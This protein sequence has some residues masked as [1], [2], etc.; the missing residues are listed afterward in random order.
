[1]S[2]LAARTFLNKRAPDDKDKLA[3]KLEDTKVRAHY[4]PHIPSHRRWIAWRSLLGTW[5]TQ[6]PRGIPKEVFALQDPETLYD[7][8]TSKHQ[9]TKEESF[10]HSK[11]MRDECL[12]ITDEV[13]HKREIRMKALEKSRKQR[14]RALEEALKGPEFNWS[15]EKR[16]Y[17]PVYEHS[18]RMP[19]AS[20]LAQ[21][22]VERA[23][24]LR[25]KKERDILYGDGNVENSTDN[26][27][28]IAPELE[29]CSEEKL[30]SRFFKKEENQTWLWLYGLTSIHDIHIVR[31]VFLLLGIFQV[32]RILTPST[33]QPIIPWIFA[34]GRRMQHLKKVIHQH[35]HNRWGIDPQSLL[36]MD[37]IDERTELAVALQKAR[38]QRVI[39]RK[40]RNN[41]LRILPFYLLSSRVDK[42]KLLRFQDLGEAAGF[43]QRKLLGDHGKSRLKTENIMSARKE[44]DNERYPGHY[45]ELPFYQKVLYELGVDSKTGLPLHSVEVEQM[46]TMKCETREFESDNSQKLEA[47]SEASS[48][49]EGTLTPQGSDSEVFH[50]SENNTHSENV[51]LHYQMPTYEAIHE[52]CL[53]VLSEEDER[54]KEALQYIDVHEYVEI[55]Q[56]L[57][58]AGE[59]NSSILSLP[60][61][62]KVGE[63]E[64]SYFDRSTLRRTSSL[65]AERSIPISGPEQREIENHPLEIDYSAIDYQICHLSFEPPILNRTSQATTIQI[66]C[67]N[68]ISPEKNEQLR[69]LENMMIENGAEDS[70][71]LKSCFE[72][73][74][75][76]EILQVASCYSLADCDDQ[77]VM[78]HCIESLAE[79]SF[80]FD[81]WRRE[82]ILDSSEESPTESVTSSHV[83]SALSLCP[84]SGTLPYGDNVESSTSNFFAP[85]G[86][87][88]NLLKLN[89]DNTSDGSPVSPDMEFGTQ[90]KD[91]KGGYGA[92]VGDL[93]GLIN[94]M[95]DANN[96]SHEQVKYNLELDGEENNMV[97]IQAR[98]DPYSDSHEELRQTRSADLQRTSPLI[99]S[100]CSPR[101]ELGSEN[102]REY[103]PL[104][105]PKRKLPYNSDCEDEVHRSRGSQVRLERTGDQVSRMRPGGQ[106]IFLRIKRNPMHHAKGC[107]QIVETFS[108]TK[109]WS[110]QR[111]R[112]Q[113]ANSVR[114]RRLIF[115]RCFDSSKRLK[116]KLQVLPP[117]VE[118]AAIDAI[119]PFNKMS[120]CGV[121]ATTPEEPVPDIALKQ[122]LHTNT[123]DISCPLVYMPVLSHARRTVLSTLIARNKKW[124]VSRLY[125]SLLRNMK[126]KIFHFTLS[127]FCCLKR[128]KVLL[129]DLRSLFY[130]MLSNLSILLSFKRPIFQQLTYVFVV[131]ESEINSE[132]VH[133]SLQGQD[134]IRKICAVKVGPLMSISSAER[135]SREESLFSSRLDVVFYNWGVS[136]S[137]PF[138]PILTSRSFGDVRVKGRNPVRDGALSSGGALHEN[139]NISHSGDS[140]GQS[141]LQNDEYVSGRFAER[142]TQIVKSEELFSTG[143][144]MDI[145]GL[146]VSKIPA[147]EMEFYYDFDY[148]I[149]EL[150]TSAA[151]RLFLNRLRSEVFTVPVY[152]SHC[153]KQG[154]HDQAQ[155]VS[156]ES[157]TSRE[158]CT[159]RP[160]TEKSFFSF[161][162]KAGRVPETDK[163][164]SQEVSTSNESPKSQNLSPDCT[165]L[166][167]ECKLTNP[168][169]GVFEK[170][171][172]GN[173][174][175]YLSR[176]RQEAEPPSE[177]AILLA[178]KFSALPN[179]AL[180]TLFKDH[181]NFRVFWEDDFKHGS[182]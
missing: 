63:I 157:E 110:L 127:V 60:A 54:F 90:I 33:F 80:D 59:S 19:I 145:I 13:R 20:R 109:F 45:T 11:N 139:S 122:F 25:K 77:I 180:F 21:L 103:F 89:T 169:G 168:I 152:L 46:T 64:A 135:Y 31:L 161:F 178:N 41:S 101:F 86:Y 175:N 35:E 62:L 116:P 97:Q 176:K 49:K 106:S 111:K 3:G 91:C 58:F 149:D 27:R 5:S 18:S 95:G 61:P 143:T 48:V 177:L 93:E 39:A 15:K 71:S 134:E 125:L 121:G 174:E 94:Q 28:I 40:G 99:E 115:E 37:Y 34:L 126:F 167:A 66:S 12:T 2:W 156:Q 164:G 113:I 1:M 79:Q 43:S 117:L 105:Q 124:S 151:G 24:V 108:A 68:D 10:C 138:F 65:Q 17:V 7:L 107:W 8:S 146:V 133:S 132:E 69:Q 166:L 130:T 50:G 57:M 42:F 70:Q 4:L 118:R 23:E 163:K 165:N 67:A 92:V 119:R 137:R 104:V 147:E 73:E 100:L 154:S 172:S 55:N 123:P 56:D 144:E 120:L 16:K 38:T 74:H 136:I 52:Q 173:V 150:R 83:H 84:R 128:S 162:R 82:G 140:S 88:D 36:W 155:A 6:A 141:T 114:R 148:T 29:G 22:E 182:M 158:S 170:W 131:S 98:N 142:Q 53:D 44:T 72:K 179:D 160:K 87:S 181:P 85:S 159:H 75:P 78:H 30:S 14:L 102:D 26:W 81:D 129:K 171:L 96:S 9:L 76:A 51:H 32:W 153:L 112:R 47:N